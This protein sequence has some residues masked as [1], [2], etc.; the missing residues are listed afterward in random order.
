M[1]GLSQVPTPRNEPVRTYAHGSPERTRL[2]AALEMMAQDVTEVPLVVWGKHVHTGDLVD[3]VMPHAHHHVVGRAHRGDKSHA[4]A[5]IRAALEA[6]RSWSRLPWE[7]R[8][9]VFL[10]A[11]DLLAGPFRD[12]MNAATMLGQSKTAHQSE[13]DAVCELADFWRFNVHFYTQLMREQPYSP[14]GQW[15]RTE[16]RPLDGFVFAVTP[17]NFTSIAANLCTAP[18]LLG[19]VVVWKPADTQLLS[20]HVIMEVLEAAGLPPGVVNMVIGRPAELGEAV[21][22]S[23]DLGGLHFT[24]STATFNHLQAEIARHLGHYKQYP[25]IVGETGGKDFVFAHPSADVEALAVAIL[26]GGFEYQGQKCSAASRVYVPESLWPRLRERLVD[27]V[28]GLA[29]GDVRDF[30]NFMGA[31]IDARAAIRP[32]ACSPAAPAPTT[33]AG[34]CGPRS[35]RCRILCTR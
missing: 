22:G 35:S 8:A 30:R 5:A 28:Q 3:V 1:S 19:N 16:L 11:A 12:R 13:I 29:V 9:A 23:P 18:A 14:E 20:A 25:R 31:V 6:K 7:E 24:G 26:R 27:E 34:S 21:L 17:F 2:K 10:K 32:R 4:E 33:S 15:N